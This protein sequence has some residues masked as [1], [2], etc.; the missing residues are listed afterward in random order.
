MVPNAALLVS[1]DRFSWAVYRPLAA[2]SRLAW[3]VGPPRCDRG[4]RLIRLGP[5]SAESAPQTID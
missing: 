5:R 2:R 1:I 3:D 4:P